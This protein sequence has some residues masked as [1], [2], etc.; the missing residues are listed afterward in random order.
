MVFI[1]DLALTLDMCNIKE[2]S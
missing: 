1:I 2:I